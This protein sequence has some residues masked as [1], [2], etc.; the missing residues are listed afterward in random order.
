MQILIATHGLSF[1]PRNISLIL[2]GLRFDLP[3]QVISWKEKA[4]PF[5]LPHDPKPPEE[6]YNLVAEKVL[7]RMSN[8][9]S[10]DEDNNMDC[11]LGSPLAPPEQTITQNQLV[12]IDKNLL[13]DILNDMLIGESKPTHCS[14][15]QGFC[16]RKE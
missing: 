16:T 8:Y 1:I 11:P 4:F 7:V 6:A 14:P 10:S 9:A 2:Q 5:K 12:M 15:H 3:I 13:R